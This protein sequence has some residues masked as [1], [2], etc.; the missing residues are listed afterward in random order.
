MQHAH[1]QGVL[2]RDIKPENL[3]FDGAGSMKVTDFGIAQVVDSTQTRTGVILGTPSYMAPE[4]AAGN[5]G[6]IGPASDVYSLGAVLYELLTGFRPFRANNLSKLL[7]QIVFAT[8]PPLHSL[9][10]MPSP[11]PKCIT[12]RCGDRPS[13]TA[14]RLRRDSR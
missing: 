2:H 10:S 4:Q 6:N 8:P 13:T 1:E 5:R 12:S 7:H 14:S 9:L 11:A 3:M